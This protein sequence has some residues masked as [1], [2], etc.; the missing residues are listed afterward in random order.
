M[1]E[2]RARTLMTQLNRENFD[3]SW[4]NSGLGLEQTLAGA[5]SLSYASL[6]EE[7]I[8]FVPLQTTQQLHE[9]IFSGPK[10]IWHD[11]TTLY[12]FLDG[13]LLPLKNWN[14]KIIAGVLEEKALSELKSYSQKVL[15]RPEML[16][17]CHTFQRFALHN[18]AYLEKMHQQLTPLMQKETGRELQ[19][20]YA[21]LSLYGNKGYCPPH[22]DH[23]RCQWTLDLCVSQDQE[24]PLFVEDKKFLLKENDALIYSGTDQLHWRER[25]HTNGHCNLVFFHFK[26][27]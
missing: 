3:R 15:L 10:E 23:H 1:I 11:N 4:K 26:E 19:P 5:D 16:I 25:I 17:H 18:S 14:P 13:H 9:F 8:S 22:R 21:Y 20:T 6:L 24:W 7:L 2:A 12:E 27:K